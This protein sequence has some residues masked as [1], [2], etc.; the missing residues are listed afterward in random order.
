MSGRGGGKSQSVTMN[1]HVII[2]DVPLRSEPVGLEEEGK[3]RKRGKGG[4]AGR[5][6]DGK[7]GGQEEG[8]MGRRG[9]RRKEGW[10]GERQEE[11]RMGKKE[12][13]REG[14]EKREC[15]HI[16]RELRDREY[17]HLLSTPFGR[18]LQR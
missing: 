7:A 8:R 5:R 17:K 12:G 15:Q 3:G 2:P 16:T 10:E 11:G 13:R 1:S 9:G 6:E 18:P 14:K 4:R